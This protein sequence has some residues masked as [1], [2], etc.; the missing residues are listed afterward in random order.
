MTT[1]HIVYTDTHE[2]AHPQDDHSVR[3]GLDPQ[4][5]ERFLEIRQVE[6]TNTGETLE[7]GDTF[8]VIYTN[9]GDHDLTMPVTG[10]VMTQNEDVLERPSLMMSES[11][12]LNWLLEIELVDDDA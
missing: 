2:Y 7:A 5:A 12:E 8:G 4:V 1:D 11:F 10:V 6:L 9:E 3:V